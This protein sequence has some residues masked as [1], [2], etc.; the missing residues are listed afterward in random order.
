M[1]RNPHSPFGDGIDRN[2]A[3]KFQFLAGNIYTRNQRVEIGRI[4]FASQLD[5]EHATVSRVLITINGV[6]EHPQ[7]FAHLVH[8]LPIKGDPHHRNRDP[9]ENRQ[10]AGGNDQ[11]DQRK[12]VL[13]V[14][15]PQ[16]PFTG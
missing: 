12:A 9:D 10:D 6:A 1:E 11:L 5:L 7:V 8:A 14:I 15:C 13:L 4:A 3:E 2:P 16:N